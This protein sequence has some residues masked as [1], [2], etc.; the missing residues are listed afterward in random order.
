[1]RRG[2]RLGAQTIELS[3]HVVGA[4]SAQRFGVIGAVDTDHQ[5]KVSG[6]SCGHAGFSV[7]DD[8]RA[9]RRYVEPVSGGN[10]GIWRGL[11]GE[12]FVVGVVTVDHRVE[13]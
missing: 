3:H 10:E 8:C 1:L 7:L 5:R 13:L 11:A 4:M 6:A 9:R 2:K 12:P